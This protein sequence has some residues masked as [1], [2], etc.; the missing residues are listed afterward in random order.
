MDRDGGQQPGEV[1]DSNND[2]DIDQPEVSQS[3][4]DDGD[5]GD[6][7]SLVIRSRSL[8]MSSW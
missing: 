6:L 3:A 8:N 7:I 1:Y 4:A 2:S 5:D